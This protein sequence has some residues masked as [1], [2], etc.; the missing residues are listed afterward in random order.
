[1]VFFRKWVNSFMA[2]VSDYLQVPGYISYKTKQFKVKLIILKCYCCGCFHEEMSSTRI[3]SDKNAI[4][5]K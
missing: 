2:L 1:M 3:T 5:N 4:I